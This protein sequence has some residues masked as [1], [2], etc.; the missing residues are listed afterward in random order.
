MA[1]EK[2]PRS[3]SNYLEFGVRLYRE[4]FPQLTA[5]AL[6]AYL[7]LAA[8][9]LYIH[10][11]MESILKSAESAFDLVPRMLFAQLIIRVLQTFVLVLIILRI[12]ARRKG[13]E[14]V[15]DISEAFSRLGRVAAVDLTY[16]I[17]IQAV[18]ILALWFALMAAGV[19]MGESPMVLPI[20]A[21]IAAF[22]L[23]GPAIRYYFAS[24]VSL[25]H[26][27]PFIESFRMAG[28]V[29]SGGERLI[30]T[31]VMTYMM[32]WFIVWQLSHAFFGGGMAGQIMVQAGVMVT[33]IPYFFAGYLLYLDLVPMAEDRVTISQ[34]G[35][36]EPTDSPD[37]GAG[38]GGPGGAEE[39]EPRE[40]RPGAE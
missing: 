36:E 10:P 39:E 35:R 16:A 15:W 27:T 34:E 12:E 23:I 22:V 33:S 2:S 14:N 13:D 8:L 5:G 7:P 20:A 24:M 9:A 1:E 29:S 30:F 40:T 26:A 37:G 38:P 18:G 11:P 3:L 25:L 28:A 32:V 6:I 4:D 21:T 17:G 31:L 19:V